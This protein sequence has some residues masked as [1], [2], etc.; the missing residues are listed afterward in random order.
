MLSGERVDQGGLPGVALPDDCDLHIDFGFRIALVFWD[1]LEELVEH[2]SAEVFGGRG[3]EQG[4][5]E[6]EGREFVGVGFPAGVVAFG[7]DDMDRGELGVFDAVFVS[8]TEFLFAEHLSNRLVLC[9]DPGLAVHGKE[10]DVCS[11]H[12]LC[13]LV[14][15]VV[16]QRREVRADLVVSCALSDIDPETSGIGQLDLLRGSL[17]VEGVAWVDEIDDDRESISGHAWRVVN[18][19]DPL[20]GDEIEEGGLAD[21]GSADDGDAGDGHSRG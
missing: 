17:L 20:L 14:L 9:R 3:A 7:R 1:D 2:V 21:I 4:S 6:S 16:G 11:R 19:R 12:G 13:D 5:A 15:D 18:D 10:D 8:A